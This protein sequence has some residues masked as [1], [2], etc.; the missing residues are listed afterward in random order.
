MAIVGY[1]ELNESGEFVIGFAKMLVVN[2]PATEAPSGVNPFTK[3]PIEF[4]ASQ[5]ASRP[6]RH[7]P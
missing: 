7:H 5:L 6:R 3:E 1:R 4:A 2:K